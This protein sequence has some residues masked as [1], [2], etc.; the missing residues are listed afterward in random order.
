[1]AILVSTV[2]ENPWK[3]LSDIFGII[4][5]LMNRNFK[6]FYHMKIVQNRKLNKIDSLTP[7]N[8]NFQ[9]YRNIDL[10]K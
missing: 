10:Q 7:S 2:G 8:H 6:D 4:F 9:I 1:M 3:Y 5:T